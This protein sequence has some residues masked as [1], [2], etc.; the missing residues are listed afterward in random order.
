MSDLDCYNSRRNNRR[1]SS[2][3]HR[4]SRSFSESPERRHMSRDH[5]RSRQARER[6]QASRCIGVFGLNT[7]TTQHKVRELFSKFGPIE[8]IQMVIDAHTH[9]SRGFCF[10]YFLNL[11][12]ARAAKDACSGMDV[13]DRRIRVDY[14]ITHR[15]HTP[16][17]GVYMGRPSRYTNRSRDRYG[18]SNSDSSRSRRRGRDSSTSPYDNYRRHCNG[19]RDHRYR[20]HR[21]KSSS[22]NRY[23]RSRSR[24]EE[25]RSRSRRRESR[26]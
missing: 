19:E 14:S 4:R 23:D 16:T 13:D 2:Q 10:I 5:Q 26:Y 20:Q 9:R 25:S 15:P 21:H 18:F 17:P 22:R 7:N 11:S 6:P 8:R 1:S 12:D 3:N 24:S